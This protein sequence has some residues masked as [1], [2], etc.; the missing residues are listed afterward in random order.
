[1]S[2]EKYFTATNI[3]TATDHSCQTSQRLFSLLFYDIVFLLVLLAIV[4]L[5]SKTKRAAF[6]V[7]KELH[8]LF[9]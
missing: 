3:L 6:A 5:L 9:Q 8:R 1:M 4:V 7:M 2:P